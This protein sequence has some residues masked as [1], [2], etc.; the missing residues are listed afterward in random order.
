MKKK[1]SIFLLVSLIFIGCSK[2]KTEIASLNQSDSVAI[3]NIISTVPALETIISDLNFDGKLD[4]C[5]VMIPPNDGEPGEFREVFVSLNGGVK[6]RIG[7]FESWNPIDSSFIAD[8]KQ[9]DV[10]SKRVYAY[11]DHGKTFM[12]LFGY[13]FGSGR[14]FQIIEIEKFKI[15]TV[16]DKEYFEIVFFG[17]ENKDDLLKL[18]VRNYPEMYS[19][20]DS[21]DA[22]IGTYDPYLVYKYKGEFIIDESASKAYNIEHY[23]WDGLKYDNEK[24][25]LYPRNEKPRFIE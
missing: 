6:S 23:I 24:K 19:T 15:K 18:I 12:L 11:K 25:V 3:N 9:N 13:M 17:K 20:V 5:F 21:L 4:T 7:S 8:N 22:Y 14:P 10:N 1:N 16:F 2:P